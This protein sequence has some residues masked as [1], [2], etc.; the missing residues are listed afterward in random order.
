MSVMTFI[1]FVQKS[2]AT[3]LEDGSKMVLQR[4]YQTHGE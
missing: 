3:L 2:W 4:N 1:K